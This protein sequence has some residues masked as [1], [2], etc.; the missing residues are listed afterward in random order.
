MRRTGTVFLLLSVVVAVSFGWIGRTSAQD[1]ERDLGEV[2][3]IAEELFQ[4]AA[5]RKFN[6]LYDRIHPD[7]H[8]VVPRAAAVGTFAEVY[9][10]VQAGR[11][12]ITDARI[13]EWTWGVTGETYPEAAE[14]SFRQPYVDEDGQEQWLEDRMYLVESD[15][16]WRWFFGSDAE[17]VEEAIERFGGR[18]QPLTEGDLIVNVVN[19]LDVFYRDVFSYTAYP[20][21]SPG[22]VVVAPGDSAMSAC[23]PAEGAFWGFYCPL[24]QTIYLDEALLTQLQQSADFAAAFVIAHE[25]AHHV[26]TSAEFERVDPGERPDEW[27]EVFSVELELMADCMSGA[28]ALDVDTRGLLETDDVDEAIAFTVERLGDPAFIGEYDPQ[29]HGTADQ[30]AQSI[31]LGY[32]QGFLGCNIAI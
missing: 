3:A 26:Q 29:A 23:G 27:N 32:E 20:Y 5:E 2:I 10:V 13:T 12:E 4:L 31:L 25:W 15:G 22:V 30:R 21:H 19:D 18:G 9:E 6:A 16:E 8:A 14:I 11:A 17:F 24:D 1:A 28:W 7:A